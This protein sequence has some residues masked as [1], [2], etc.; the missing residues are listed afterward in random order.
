MR[1]PFLIGK[2]IYL[3]SP[4]PGDEAIIS[5]SENHPDTR[6]HLYIAF[7]TSLEM[8][9]NSIKTKSHDPNTILFTIATIEPDEPIGTTSFVRIDWA[10]R[11]A[12]FYIA[13][14]EK[15]KWSKGYGRE[16]TKIMVDY[17]FDTLN[18]NRI[19]LHVSTENERAIKVYDDIGFKVEGKLRQAMFYGN[20]Y[21]DFLLMAILK[22][23]WEDKLNK[24]S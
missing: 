6:S 9:Y 10:G 5:L 12:T 2:Q 17:A 11:M 13:I 4:E 15:E 18:M 22:K 7:P 23:D 19:Q 24:S 8:Q 20:K 3:R 1:N 21:I 14:A 16:T